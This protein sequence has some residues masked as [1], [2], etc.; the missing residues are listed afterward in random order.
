V[1]A[2]IRP[3]LATDAEAIAHLCG[4]LGY[5]ATAVDIEVRRAAI[6][7]SA[8]HV[9]LVA[10]VDGAVLGWLHACVVHSI[11]YERLVEIRGLVVDARARSRA[12]GRAL[13]DEAERWART[14][15]VA[16]MRVRSRVA[17]ERAH[18]FYE[19]AGYVAVKQQ[20]VFDKVLERA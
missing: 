14:R 2:H 1:S 18:R 9:L 8:D 20:K 6:G 7:D 17:R 15:G 13:L 5:P 10:E 11:E 12:L 4:E 16:R 3:A 19:R